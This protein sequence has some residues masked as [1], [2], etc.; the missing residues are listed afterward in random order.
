MRW[1]MLILLVAL[2]GLYGL[3][4]EIKKHMNDMWGALHTKL[5]DLSSRVDEI[6]SELDIDDK[7]SEYSKLEGIQSK[8][9]EI[10]DYQQRLLW[11]KGTPYEYDHI[12]TVC[13]FSW[14]GFP[15]DKARWD[16]SKVTIKEWSML[17]DLQRK[18][19]VFEYYFHLNMSQPKLKKLRIT[20]ISNY[21][22]KTLNDFP[23]KN[24]PIIN[25]IED[26]LK[27]QHEEEI[28]RKEEKRKEIFGEVL[29]SREEIEKRE[30]RARDLG[31]IEIFKRLCLNIYWYSQW[32]KDPDKKQLIPSSVTNAVLLQSNIVGRNKVN[33]GSS[34]EIKINLS[35]KDYTFHF[36]EKNF[37]LHD[38]TFRTI[39]ILELFSEDKKVLE[40]IG[41]L[42][43][44]G[45]C[46]FHDDEYLYVKTFVEGDWINDFKKLYD[47]IE[48]QK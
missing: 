14:F 45:F 21:I 2:W 44:S 48:S 22:P 11:N 47:E 30:Q 1:I 40:L 23:D 31:V 3:Y 25:I 13:F 26:F 27:E 32:S 38:K 5:D 4:E 39:G 28:K 8:L 15:Q 41:Q 33:R 43:N 10:E 29:E 37:Q 24:T 36:E 9:E 16:G 35:R 46:C 12:P 7:K 34:F 20:D 17:T 42:G 6:K 18:K 19:Y